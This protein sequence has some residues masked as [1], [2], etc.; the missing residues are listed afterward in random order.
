MIRSIGGLNSFGLSCRVIHNDTIDM[1][2]GNE[3]IHQPRSRLY[4]D[5]SSSAGRRGSALGAIGDLLAGC[6]YL[7]SAD[8]DC[9]SNAACLLD[10]C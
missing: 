10:S 2:A 9:Q 8:Q 4:L 7:A 6:I 3:S 5:S 1:Y